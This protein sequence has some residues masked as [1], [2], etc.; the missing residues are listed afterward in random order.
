[1][2]EVAVWS[3]QPDI[4]EIGMPEEAISPAT[5]HALICNG[6]FLDSAS[7]RILALWQEMHTCAGAEGCNFAFAQPWEE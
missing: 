2:Q 7:N 1:M 4:S 3:I 5:E 6:H